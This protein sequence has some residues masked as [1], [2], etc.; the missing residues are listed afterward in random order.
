MPIINS[1]GTLTYPKVYYYSL[2]T[3]SW[4]SLITGKINSLYTPVNTAGTNF[5][6]TNIRTDSS[7]NSYI[8]TTDVNTVTFDHSAGLLSELDLDG[9]NTSIIGFSTAGAV[10]ILGSVQDSSGNDCVVGVNTRVVGA[11]YY[12]SFYVAKFDSSGTLI[13][14]NVLYSAFNNDSSF[15]IQI[16]SSDNLYLIG[17]SRGGSPA[18]RYG[19]FFKVDSSGSLVW[20][21]YKNDSTADVDI[22]SHVIDASNNLYFITTDS[23]NY[24]IEKYNSS[25]TNQ[26]IKQIN[27][28]IKS[29]CL[30]GSNIAVSTLDGIIVLNS[31]GSILGQKSAGLGATNTRICSDSSNNLFV[32]GSLNSSPYQIKVCKF[33]NTYTTS[34]ASQITTTYASQAAILSGIAMNNNDDNITL[35]FEQY[36]ASPTNN[37]M[38]WAYNLPSNGLIPRRGIYTVGGYRTEY[39]KISAVNSSTSFTS[40]TATGLSTGSLSLTSTSV[41]TTFSTGSNLWTNLI[42]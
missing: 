41:S 38:M 32:I 11:N 35:A 34:W 22:L 3:G 21:Y 23:T 5:S 28:T 6:S 1:L 4:I 24:Y 19:D 29:I 39:H 20:S 13:W 7:F 2:P 15:G 9:Y 36:Q 33:D 26:W 8:G 14:Q 10:K 25:G 18:R 17:T 16:D 12:Y 42:L 27:T 31:S 37:N 40:T 30:V